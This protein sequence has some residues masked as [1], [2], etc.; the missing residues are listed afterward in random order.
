MI[1]LGQKTHEAPLRIVLCRM[2]S[3]QNTAK[4]LDLMRSLLQKSINRE[5]DMI[6]QKYIEV[7]VYQI[8]LSSMIS[9][10]TGGLTMIMIHIVVA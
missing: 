4:S 8:N 3:I 1:C 9:S 7:F 5:I 2:G 10:V 6:I